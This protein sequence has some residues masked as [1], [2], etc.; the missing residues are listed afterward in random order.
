MHETTANN[1]MFILE[2]CKPGRVYLKLKSSSLDQYQVII[3]FE[4]SMIDHKPRR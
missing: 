2:Q 3:D 4:L 1:T